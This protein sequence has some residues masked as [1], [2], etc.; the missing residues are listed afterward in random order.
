MKTNLKKIIFLLLGTL[1]SNFWFLEIAQAG[2]LSCTLRTSA[3]N[4]G[5]TEIFALE[6]TTNSHA[7]LAVQSNYN[8][9]VCC[10]GVSGLGN[11]CSGNYATVVKLSG[12]SNAHLEQNSQANYVG[13][14]ACLSVPVG[15]SVSVGYQS[16]SCSGYDTT[17]AS[18]SGSTN[19]HGGDGNAYATKICATASAASGSVAIDVVDAGGASVASP[20]V[21]FGSSNFWWSTQQSSGILGSSA[22]KLRLTSTLANWT[23][24]L[25]AT[26]GP[27]A[28]WQSGG[29]S[30]DFNGDLAA[31]RLQLDPSVG[32]ITAQSG[33]ANAGLSKGSASYFTQGTQDSLTLLSGSSAQTGCYWDFTGINLIQDLPSSQAVGSYTLGMTLTAA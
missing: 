28:L 19:A 10:S 9:L 5:E 31:G 22:Q 24:S 14:E 3:C 20:V 7:E 23:L 30:Y 17:L 21:N 18:I 29:N 25:A 6:N 1:V 15:G 27:T 8:N 16:S 33:C 32:T 13:N 26:N 4:G 2:T 11:S 12:S